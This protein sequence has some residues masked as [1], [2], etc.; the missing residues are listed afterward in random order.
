MLLGT[1]N[2]GDGLAM[3]MLCAPDTCKQLHGTTSKP[4]TGVGILAVHEHIP[5]THLGIHNR[6]ERTPSDMPHCKTR[7][8]I[9]GTHKT[10][11]NHDMWAVL[12][13]P[14]RTSSR[15][16]PL[17]DTP[18]SNQAAT[19]ATRHRSPCDVPGALAARARPASCNPCVGDA[20]PDN[21]DTTRTRQHT[22]ITLTSCRHPAEES[23]PSTRKYWCQRS[24]VAHA[25][26]SLST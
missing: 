18:P 10:G 9:R 17:S 23:T 19:L 15:V 13:I 16:T 5:I 8:E 4:V 12:T 7:H 3:T 1:N 21:G 26:Y 25:R 22:R 20:V 14:K 11:Y 2:V 6:L 24:S